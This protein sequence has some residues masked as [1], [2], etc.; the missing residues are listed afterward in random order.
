MFE[1]LYGGLLPILRFR[2]EQPPFIC[3]VPMDSRFGVDADD[4]DVSALK[5]TLP[6]LPGN[7]ECCHKN[8][9]VVSNTNSLVA[10]TNATHDVVAW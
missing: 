9:P 7:P 2:S 3:I 10:L 5:G 6:Q 4:P 1:A 8:R